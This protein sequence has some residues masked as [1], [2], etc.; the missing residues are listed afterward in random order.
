MNLKQ[1][2]QSALATNQDPTKTVEGA[3]QSE[4]LRN[5]AVFAAER[6]AAAFLKSR[7]RVAKNQ[8]VTAFADLKEASRQAKNL[9]NCIMQAFSIDLDA[10]RIVENFCGFGREWRPRDEAVAAFAAEHGIDHDTAREALECTMMAAQLKSQTHKGNRAAIYMAWLS[11][12]DAENAQPND[13]TRSVIDVIVQEAYARAGEWLRADEGILI[14]GAADD[15]GVVLPQW[16]DVL[17]KMGANQAAARARVQKN[18]DTH[19]QRM[20]VELEEATK[21]IDPSDW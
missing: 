19:A 18:L 9:T 8:A 5:G 15:L 20:A 4:I 16:K 17:P 11:D 21:E 12:L 6:A 14:K 1:A 7:E 3:G 13:A 10:N 2:L